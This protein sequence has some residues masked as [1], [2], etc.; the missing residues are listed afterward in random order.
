MGLSYAP[1]AWF[2]WQIVGMGIRKVAVSIPCEQ[3]KGKISY[4]FF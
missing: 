3:K 4:I 2:R 1:K